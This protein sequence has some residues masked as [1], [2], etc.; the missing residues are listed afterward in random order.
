MK[1]NNQQVLSYCA[2]ALL[3]RMMCELEQVLQ[4]CNKE[5]YVKTKKAIML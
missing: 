5:N 3:T 2:H 1:M 4:V